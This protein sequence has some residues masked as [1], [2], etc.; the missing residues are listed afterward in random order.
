MKTLYSLG[1][2]GNYLTKTEARR[3]PRR[4]IALDGNRKLPMESIR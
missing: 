2:D 1:I 3:A 4:L